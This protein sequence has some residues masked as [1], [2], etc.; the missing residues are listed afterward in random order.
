[1]RPGNVTVDFIHRTEQGYDFRNKI[2]VAL[3][4]TEIGEFAVV[5]LKD[6]PLEFTRA[7]YQPM[8][9]ESKVVKSMSVSEG[10]GGYVFSAS[11]LDDGQQIDV[12]VTDAEFFVI[13]TLM[14][15]SLPYLA[16]F[17]QTFSPMSQV[18]DYLRQTDDGAPT[19]MF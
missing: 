16:G 13:K 11:Q 4:P 15:S 17:P 1:M 18:P 8:E 2:S 14:F 9:N 10:P 5:D 3:S 7:M 19:G 12:E 6:A